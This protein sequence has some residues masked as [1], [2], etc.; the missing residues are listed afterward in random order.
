M[1]KLDHYSKFEVI[2]SVIR[3]N[4]SSWNDSRYFFL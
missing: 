1:K 3:R 2:Y 4:F